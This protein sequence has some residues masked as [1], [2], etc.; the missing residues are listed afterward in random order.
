MERTAIAEAQTLKTKQQNSRIS[1]QS[2]QL[3]PDNQLL[4]LQNTIGN[5][6]VQ[7]LLRAQQQSAGK[8][9]FPQSVQ[10]PSMTPEL[11]QEMN[12]D[13]E[14]ITK[15]I[16]EDSLNFN[17]RV[18]IVER[19]K[20]WDRA[21]KQYAESTGY[22]D[23]FYLDKFIVK[24]KVKSLTISSIRTFWQDEHLLLFDALLDGLKGYP[25]DEFKRLV[26]ASKRDNSTK[27]QMERIENFWGMMGK[28]EAM[29]LWGMTK[30]LGVGLAGLVDS[31]AGGANAALHVLQINTPEIPSLAKYLSNQFDESGKIMFGDSY[32]REKLF[33]GLSAADVGEIG[34]TVI[35]NLVMMGKGRA[36]SKAIAE[37]VSAGKKVGTGLKATEA[38][39]KTVDFLGNFKTIEDSIKN[40]LTAVEKMQESAR[41]N[42]QRPPTLGDMLS[43]ADVA[44]E[45]TNLANGLFG[46]FTS[47]GGA[48]S[49]E[50]RKLVQRIGMLLNISQMSGM[51]AKITDIMSSDGTPDEKTKEIAMLLGNLFTTAVGF[52]YSAKDYRDEVKTDK[53]AKDAIKRKE[54]E[55]AAQLSD[56]KP[57]HVSEPPVKEQAKT[58]EKPKTAAPE[59]SE[60]V[61]TL[62]LPEAAHQKPD[63]ISEAIQ[64]E[65]DTSPQSYEE[66]GGKPLN[67][68]EFQQKIGSEK[69]SEVAGKPRAK[70][71]DEVKSILAE[72]EKYPNVMFDSGINDFKMEAVFKELNKTAAGSQIVDLITEGKIHVVFTREEVLQGYQ[73]AQTG[74]EISVVWGASVETAVS[75]LIHEGT[76]FTTGDDIKHLTTGSRLENE[77]MARAFEY[78]YNMIS[79]LPVYDEAEL[80]YRSTFTKVLEETGNPAVARSKADAAMINE[81]KKDPQRYGVETPKDVEEASVAVMNDALDN[82]GKQ[83]ES[84]PDFY[85]DTSEFDKAGP[86]A[87][88]P[89]KKNNQKKFIQEKKKEKET[90]DTGVSKVDDFTGTLRGIEV[91]LPGVKTK[92][93][94][95]TKR[96][97]VETEELRK[98]FDS[99]ERKKF[100]KDL[101]KDTE[102]LKKA[103]L[104]DA[105]ITDMEDGLVPEGWN[106]HHK[107]PLDDGGDNSLENLVLIK[108]EPYHKTITNFQNS[109]AKLLNPGEIK[110]V[111]WP[112]PDS[113]IYPPGE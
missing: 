15:C 61:K 73:G 47:M 79:D 37:A 68:E 12:G 11:E 71:M 14:W 87:G 97:P 19:L 55:A 46:L 2:R 59:P 109:F 32:G 5:R 83:K 8:P 27:P 54:S 22:A 26:A 33:W 20:R 66:P 31:A 41:R 111:E 82:F 23:T 75:T 113:S 45:L 58:P 13:I 43:N 98:A 92:E 16:K 112:I 1:N 96:N 99:T 70:S 102:K 51:L 90:K 104:S 38:V 65:L 4:A 28:Q 48:S 77:A 60:P 80:A 35:W 50:G 86:L 42:G 72:H 95:Y 91:Q 40:I 103:G 6:A 105:D 39:L 7:E 84:E 67:A 63:P 93:I 34:G 17:I 3:A 89:S 36:N 53:A 108:N 9:D 52:G 85:I 56:G 10:K 30:G 62:E 88:K 100:V 25:L 49:P 81:M 106:V 64:S 69:Q 110:N 107:L 18:E 29:G 74:K 94:T 44:M 101:A 24:M 57:E 78:E 76:H 21:D